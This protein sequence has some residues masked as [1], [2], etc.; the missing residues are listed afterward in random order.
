MPGNCTCGASTVGTGGWL[1]ER[2]R[3]SAMAEM[4]N[5][6]IFVATDGHAWWN[7]PLTIK[8]QA[9][10]RFAVWKPLPA[11]NQFME[12]ARYALSIAA[13]PAQPAISHSSSMAFL[14]VLPA[15]QRQAVGADVAGLLGFG[16]SL[17][18]ERSCINCTRVRAVG[19]QPQGSQRGPPV[20]VG[21]ESRIDT[22]GPGDHAPERRRGGIPIEVP[23]CGFPA[24]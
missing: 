7:A 5:H 20:S 17:A 13:A 2:M 24:G 22:G 16:S 14:Q 4:R 9:P 8:A 11:F 3:R 10:R 21:A 6:A 23:Q 12:T 18:A 19:G 15:R 1:T